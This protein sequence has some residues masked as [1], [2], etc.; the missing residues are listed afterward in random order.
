MNLLLDGA[1]MSCPTLR[2][3]LPIGLIFPETEPSQIYLAHNDLAPQDLDRLRSDR[4]LG[5]IVI[6][7]Q[8]LWRVVGIH[9][10]PRAHGRFFICRRTEAIVLDDPF[11]HPQYLTI[12]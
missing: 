6:W 11:T 12:L 2:N 7:H 10:C 8:L 5:E 9:Y 3:T 1:R 4:V